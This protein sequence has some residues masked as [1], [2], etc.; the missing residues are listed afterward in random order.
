[1]LPLI[2]LGAA[3]LIEKSS[4][5]D[6][7]KFHLG[8]DMSKHLA[9][10][11]QSK[12]GSFGEGGEV[13]ERYGTYRM[14]NGSYADVDKKGNGWYIEYIESKKQRKGDGTKIINKI[15]SDA[16]EQ[17]VKTIGLATSEGTAYGFAKKIGF[18]EVGNN[19][20]RDDIRM[21]LAVEQS[22]KETPKAG[23]F[24]VGGDIKDWDIEFTG[25]FSKG[26]KL[27][28]QKIETIDVYDDN[29]Y[30]LSFANGSVFEAKTSETIG[31]LSITDNIVKLSVILGDNT[32]T[33][34]KIIRR[35]QKLANDS[36]RVIVENNSESR[37]EKRLFPFLLVS[38]KDAPN[39]TISE[40]FIGKLETPKKAMLKKMVI[41][42]I[43]SGSFV[44]QIKKGRDA[45]EVV[46][47][48]KKAG[49]KVPEE[50]LSLTKI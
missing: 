23:S 5:P 29:I 25:G 38:K 18:K 34:Q 39:Y 15:V 28:E 41:D 26:Q 24:G 14:D 47:L 17:D 22:L 6:T 32:R 50:I 49:L 3:Y 20:N 2:L 46:E 40:L 35:L 19:K 11:E 45:N 48:I 43:N 12:A 7:D 30:S 4:Q 27:S 13:V 1:M 44:N 42:T 33:D 31:L 36:S 16:K 8:G 9:P 21:E 10:K 37:S